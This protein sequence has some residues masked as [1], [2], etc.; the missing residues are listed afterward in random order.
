MAD[1]ED[2]VEARADSREWGTRGVWRWAVLTTLSTVALTHPL[3]DVLGN[4]PQ[5]FIAR[6]EFLS[7]IVLFSFGLTLL[8]PTALWGVD[9]LAHAIHRMV[10][11]AV[12]FLV[13]A[14]LVAVALQVILNKVE[15]VTGVPSLVAAGVGGVVVAVAMFLVRDLRMVLSWLSPVALMVPILFLFGAP[16]RP[17][18]IV[19]ETG[20]RAVQSFTD[21]GPIVILVFDELSTVSL[22]GDGGAIDETMYPSFAR[23]AERSTWYRQ[24]S[25]VSDWTTVAV[26]SILTG[27]GP[28]ETA[29]RTAPTAQEH[30]NNLFT[31][32]Q[33]DFEWRALEPYTSLCPR[34]T[35][36]CNAAKSAAGGLSGWLTSYLDH[37][38]LYAHIVTPDPF[39]ASLPTI[40]ETWAGFGKV[41]GKGW[42]LTDDW[43][44]GRDQKMRKFVD[45]IEPTSTP[46]L[47]FLHLMLP[48]SPWE[49]TPS[50]ARYEPGGFKGV[51]PS[52]MWPKD[53]T[54]AEV[55]FRRYVMQLIHV[56]TLVGQLIDRLDAI[57]IWDQ[58]MV[59]ITADHGVSFHANNYRRATTP[60]NL[61][62]LAGIPLL[63]KYPHQKS[64]STS[65][66]LAQSTDIL[67]TIVDVLGGQDPWPMDGVSLRSV[68]DRPQPRDRRLRAGRWNY[69]AN[70][71]IGMIPE[72]ELEVPYLW[73]RI[74]EESSHRRSQLGHPPHPD[75][76]FGVTRYHD[77]LGTAVGD[78]GERALFS[79]FLGGDSD[80]V[81]E[82]GAARFV[83]GSVVRDAMGRPDYIALAVDGTIRATAAVGPA[84]EGAFTAVI[85]A[86]EGPVKPIEVLGIV[87]EVER[88]QLLRR[89]R[90][91]FQVRGAR[92]SAELFDGVVGN[93]KNFSFGNY[94]EP[95]LID[96]APP[97]RFSSMRLHL[98]DRGGRTHKLKV[99]ARLDDEWRLILDAS[100]LPVNGLQEIHL[101][102]KILDR[103]RI[104]G[105]WNSNLEKNPKN[106]A[107]HIYEIEFVP[108]EEK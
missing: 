15:A 51:L 102:N 96:I 3:L 9:A 6:N 48:H 42:G 5:F 61:A 82:P 81:D 12:S 32:L 79:T 77:L 83:R 19:G 98:F 74:L 91:A 13:N 90:T 24:A 73:D 22:L 72:Q 89:G 99:H 36:S 50:G 7:D 88:R 31:L 62:E 76:L 1:R 4:Y 2:S 67:P 14:A 11:T 78:T 80:G 64:G 101:P 84:P 29:G 68:G 92:R 17:L 57:G 75:K 26:P 52:G 108:R 86:L 18:V 34:A 41:I 35:P 43:S 105:I 38:L 45:G 65:D 23:L 54:V 8:L 20:T 60:G 85:P 28:A 33:G 70:V 10:G 95:F 93:P 87:H 25:A 53:P 55:G 66:F 44:E 63:I 59:I 56:D 47:H 49:Y 21:P 27:L 37:A 46:T 69:P 100:V 39:R 30:P 58:T 104:E 107:I 94:G 71:K 40:Q 103:V 106:K 16:I 97:S